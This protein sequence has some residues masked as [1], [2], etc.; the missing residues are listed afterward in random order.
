MAPERKLTIGV[1]G[2]SRVDEK[3]SKLAYETGQQIAANEAHLVCGG[4]GG[5]MEAASKGA[6][7]AGG[8]VIGLLP[9]DSREEANPYLSV[10]IPTGL[11]IGRN[12][13][14]VRAADVLI[15]FPGAYGT[16]SEMA[17]ALNLGKVVIYMPGA[18]DLTRI[19]TVDRS[20]FKEAVD[21]KHA[22]GLAL[23]IAARSEGDSGVGLSRA[24]GT[25]AEA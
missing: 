6:A 20:L 5:V 19:G 15:A 24:T 9:S 25:Q 22:I 2:G 4:L 17:L 10:A 21:A 18:W 8:T 7:E 3:T 11:G 13:L 14:V 12:V 23:G 1:I 16:L